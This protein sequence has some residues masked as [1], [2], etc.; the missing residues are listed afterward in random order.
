MSQSPLSSARDLARRLPGLEWRLVARAQGGALQ[1]LY[2]R[3]RACA[4]ATWR[5]HV[6]WYSASKFLNW[7]LSRKLFTCLTS[8]WVSSKFFTYY[9]HILYFFQIKAAIK[10]DGFLHWARELLYL[11]PFIY[12]SD[13]EH[14]IKCLNATLCAREG[15][16]LSLKVVAPKKD[17]FFW[18]IDSPLLSL[19]HFK[20][21]GIVGAT[22]IKR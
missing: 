6:T 21:W 4:V 8:P 12:V 5:F 17:V 9:E 1:P 2:G 15:S 7:S 22:G 3:S 18:C 14:A 10:P 19:M 13:K 20:T 11:K 16:F